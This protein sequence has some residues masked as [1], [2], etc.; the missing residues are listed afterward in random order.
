M[1][2]LSTPRG[3]AAHSANSGLDLNKDGVI[4]KFETA[5]MVRQQQA[6]YKPE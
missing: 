4:T 2:M 3:G 5:E 1:L 6:R